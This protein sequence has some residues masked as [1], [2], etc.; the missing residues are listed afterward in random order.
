MPGRRRSRG[1]L[2]TFTKVRHEKPPPRRTPLQRIAYGLGA[3]AIITVGVL[4]VAAFVYQL[5]HPHITFRTREA[6]APVLALS[7]PPPASRAGIVAAA[8]VELE[9]QRVAIPLTEAQRTGL[10]E[11]AVLHVKY[12]WAPSLAAVRVESWERKP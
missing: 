9:H 7:G 8:I 3:T 10:A 1:I 5:F 6:D 11:G 4:I 12:T 2:S